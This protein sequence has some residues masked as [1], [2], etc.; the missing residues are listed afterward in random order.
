MEDGRSMFNVHVH[1]CNEDTFKI[2]FFIYFI[3]QSINPFFFNN[4]KLIF[5]YAQKN[6]FNT[7]HMC[8]LVCSIWLCSARVDLEHKSHC[9]LLLYLNSIMVYTLALKKPRSM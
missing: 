5:I 8:P 2:Q 6:M 3:N 1:F 4:F 7:N 9:C